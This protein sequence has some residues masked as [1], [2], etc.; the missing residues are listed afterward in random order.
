MHMEQLRELL[1]SFPGVTE[2]EPFGP[3]V[4]VYK[5][6]GKMFALVDY[7]SVPPTMNLKCDPDRALDLRDV[8]EAIRPGWHMN[9]R[10][11]N[12]LDLDGSLRGALVTEL[13]RH[14]YDL[15]VAAQPPSAIRSNWYRKLGPVIEANPGFSARNRMDGAWLR[16]RSAGL[17]G[18]GKPAFPT[19]NH[20]YFSIFTSFCTPCRARRENVLARSRPEGDS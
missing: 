6:M 4:V 5:V 20:N 9:K 3:E 17:R 1:L 11:W 15:V 19:R 18:S 14:S 7:D 12:T 8:H 13:V 10:H 2:E 16:G